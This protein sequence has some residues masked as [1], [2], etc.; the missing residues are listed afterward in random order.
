VEVF[1]LPGFGVA[2]ISGIALLLTGLV[3]SMLRNDGL[4]FSGISS[5]AI[6][7]A[8]ASTLGGMAGALLLFLLTSRMLSKSPAFRKLVLDTAL[9][10]A[11]GFS[12]A[13]PMPAPGS[14]GIALTVLR[15][16]GKVQI[17][18]TAYAASCESGYLDAGK[19]VEV[20]SNVG[21]TLV[22]VPGS[23]P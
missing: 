6:A 19:P 4:D 5:V 14:T 10:S 11:Q 15:P 17:D 16:S 1:I 9:D 20:I 8:L 3:T 23:E 21:G 7:S 22:V 12:T 18:G 2:G 13:I